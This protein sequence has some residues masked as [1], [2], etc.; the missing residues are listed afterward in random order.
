M[1]RPWLNLSC[2]LSS[3]RFQT[4]FDAL[5]H[6]KATAIAM[7]ACLSLA[8]SSQPD[9][10]VPFSDAEGGFLL[11][12]TSGTTGLPKA[13]LISH[14]AEIARMATL[15]MDLKIE[16]DDGYLAWSPMYHIGGTEHSLSSLMMGCVCHHR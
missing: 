8:A 11:L 2:S 4:H 16:A 5:E 10:R 1:H 7:E 9:Q 15:R 14:R 13:A 3:A 12:N 6:T